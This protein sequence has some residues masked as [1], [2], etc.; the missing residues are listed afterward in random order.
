VTPI[1]FDGDVPVLTTE[2]FTLPS[3]L[4]VVVHPDHTVPLVHCS[5]WY[6]VGSSDEGPG[7]SGLAHLHEHL[8]KNSQHLAGRHHY[9]ILRRAGAAGANAST[10]ADRT[11]YHET[12]PA[13]ELDLALW[14]ESDRMGYFLPALELSRLVAQKAVVRSERRQR[15]E[16]AAYGAD[17][18]AIAEALWPEGHPHRYLTIGRH[19]DIEATSL[20]TL[21]N[22]YRTWYVPANATL[23]LAGAV[24]PRAARAHAERWFGTFPPSVRPVRPT[25]PRP[26]AVAHRGTV[27][28]R[29][30]A[31][32][33][34][35]RAWHAPGEGEAGEAE[36]DL[37]AA[38]LAQPGAGRLWQRLVYER[39]LA[40]RVQCW[41]Q[42]S[43]LG[44][45]W[46]VAVDL[47]TGADAGAVRAIL[48]EEMA[49]V[50]AE[51]PP[52]RGL[53][54]A[55]TRREAGVLWRLEGLERRAS[56]I[57]RSMLYH[58]RPDGLADELARWR[59][60]TGAS[61]QAAAA[62]W[63]AAPNVEIET[64]PLRAAQVGSPPVAAGDDLA[65][66]EL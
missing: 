61:I 1:R 58:G 19:E 27:A 50:I 35:H 48:D 56:L 8:F 5:V 62:R 65:D 40:Q 10:S 11:A 34:V 20:E 15:Y 24:D 29:F 7:E 59:G 55:Q 42:S 32:V 13:G 33:R 17:R 9:D 18:F 31:L 4:E 38:M 64:V 63:L 26:P 36:L 14:L 46:H 47:R 12:V 30:A 41:H 57:Q 21:G 51:P 3:G 2:R 52:E 22:F 16:N 66:R 45:E 28:D 39:P 43:R 49:R 6:H 53:A 25:P 37:L 60:V 23:V 44:G 54:R